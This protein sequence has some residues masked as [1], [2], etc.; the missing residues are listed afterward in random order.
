MYLPYVSDA[1]WVNKIGQLVSEIFHD[2]LINI[3]YC[4]C[5]R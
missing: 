3:A 2:H 1:L 4:H 5:L